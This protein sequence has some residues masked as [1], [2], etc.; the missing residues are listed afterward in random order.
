MG[1]DKLFVT[2]RNC[3]RCNRMCISKSH[4]IRLIRGCLYCDEHKFLDPGETYSIDGAVLVIAGEKYRYMS[5]N[6]KCAACGRKQTMYSGVDLE[7]TCSRCREK[8][9]VKGPIAPLNS[10]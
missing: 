9:R 8:F 5:R 3:P 2:K 10:S 4:H 7:F 1:E 6:V